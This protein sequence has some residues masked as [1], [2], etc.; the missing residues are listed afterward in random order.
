MT[1]AP[2]FSR[3]TT[4]LLCPSFTGAKYEKAIE[5]NVPVVDMNWLVQIVQTGVLPADNSARPTSAPARDSA[6]QKLG[7]HNTRPV[8][9]PSAGA[10]GPVGS[11]KKMMDITNSTSVITRMSALLIL[12]W[13][14]Y[15]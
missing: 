3:R 10:A 2:N 7:G 11:S 4:H 6:R 9:G 14:S 1:L 5:W 12:L 8:G 13:C 15:R